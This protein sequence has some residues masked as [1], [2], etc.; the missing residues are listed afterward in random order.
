MCKFYHAFDA[1]PIKLFFYPKIGFS[2]E[3]IGSTTI[4]GRVMMNQ[5]IYWLKR[6]E[7]KQTKVAITSIEARKN[8]SLYFQA[9]VKC[10]IIRTSGSIGM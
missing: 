1:Y 7:L 4:N 5:G 8:L 9:K 10:R 2:L 6:I 3:W